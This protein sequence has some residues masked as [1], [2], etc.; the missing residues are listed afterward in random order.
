[1]VT[2]TVQTLIDELKDLTGLS[3]ISNEKAIRALNRGVDSLS[4]IQLIASGRNKNDSINHGDVSRVTT[5]VTVGDTKVLLETEATTLQQLDILVN[6]KYQR[7]EPIDRRDNNRVPLDTTYSTPGVP[8]Y[9]DREGNHAYLY[10]TP[11]ETYTLRLT[12]GRPHPRFT[13]DNLSQS[14]GMIPLF[15]EYVI[16]YGSDYCMIGSSDTARAQV[17][18]KLVLLERKVVDTL[19]NQDEDKVRRLT[20]KLNN[21][22]SNRFSNR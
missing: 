21:A 10:P 13:T 19:K 7:V 16:A 6:G 11:D 12:Y 14:T 22:F 17:A 5:T 4:T 15:E 9:Y 20:P 18:N 2:N 3:N 1:M 8:R